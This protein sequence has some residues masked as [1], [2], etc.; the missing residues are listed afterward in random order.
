MTNAKRASARDDDFGTGGLAF[1]VDG[2]INIE[3]LDAEI[4]EAMNWRKTAGLV[5]DGVRLNE[6]TGLFGP[7]PADEGL[8]EDDSPVATV[9]V[10]H[11]NVDSKVIAKVIRDHEP[12]L[13]WQ[14]TSTSSLDD[15]IEVASKRVLRP[16]EAALAMTLLLQERKQG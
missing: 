1:E 8:G 7:V 5:L 14:G 11:E 15:L 4:V 16:E 2:P 12:D 13:A 10:T 9:T 3:Q 6:E